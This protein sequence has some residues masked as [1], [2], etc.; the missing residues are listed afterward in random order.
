MKINIRPLESTNIHQVDT[1]ERNSI[2]RS[3][4]MLDVK[5]N[6]ISY[7]IVPVEPYEKIFNIEVEEYPTFIDNPQKAIFFADVDGIPA[8]QVKIVPWWNKFAC[9]QELVVDT[10]FRGKGIGQALLNHGVEWAREHNYPGVTLETQTNN[11]SACKLYEKCG[12]VLSGF[13][14]NAYRNEPEAHDEIALF[15]YLIF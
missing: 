8:G 1:F 6:K 2:V 5:D 3:H 15:W 4:L 12:F 7:S 14:M 9:V 10:E 13:D 11:V